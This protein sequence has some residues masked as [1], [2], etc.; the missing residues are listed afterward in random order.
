MTPEQAIALVEQEAFQQFRDKYME[1]NEYYIDVIVG[2]F[3]NAIHA[4]LLCTG[5]ALVLNSAQTAIYCLKAAYEFS[6]ELNSYTTKAYGFSDFGFI[7]V[8]TDVYNKLR[9]LQTESPTILEDAKEIP[10]FICPKCNEMMNVQPN[11]CP[12]CGLQY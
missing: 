1:F 8:E 12:N 11:F 3:Y 5:R 2:D 7:Y 10:E 4:L 9:Q 6:Y